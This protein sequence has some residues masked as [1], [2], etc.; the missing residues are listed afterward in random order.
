MITSNGGG[1]NPS[2]G[3]GGFGGEGGVGGSGGIGGEGGM[4]G[5]CDGGEKE[6][7]LGSGTCVTPDP[8]NGCDDPAT[9]APCGPYANGVAMCALGDCAMDCNDPDFDDC[10][11]DDATGCEADLLNDPLNC[12]MCN[13]PCVSGICDMGTCVTEMCGSQ[14][15]PTTG[16]A[17]CLVLDSANLSATKYATVTASL[18]Q[19][20][21]PFADDPYTMNCISQEASTADNSTDPSVLCVLP[22]G[23]SGDTVYLAPKAYDSQVTNPPDPS[24]F[25]TF[26]C[27]NQDLPTAECVVP[28]RFYAN[29]GLVDT[30]TQPPTGACSYHDL[31]QPDPLQMKWVY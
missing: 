23:V 31:N 11:V 25:F 18:N 10:D 15:V 16:R 1:G 17:V 9:C 21:A 29:G 13:M 20:A 26:L 22:S 6:C 14:P 24:E 27:D 5:G 28:W 12:G 19:P 4:G 2:V 8:T 30:C 7:P 3:G